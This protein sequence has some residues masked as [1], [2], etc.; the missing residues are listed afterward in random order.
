M[1]EI[2]TVEQAEDIAALDLHEEA[3]A[4][5]GRGESVRYHCERA[6]NSGESIETLIV[7]DR[8]GQAQGGDA[9]WGDWSDK[10]QTITMDDGECPHECGCGGETG[11][12]GSTACAYGIAAVNTGREWGSSIYDSVG[13]ATRCCIS[14]YL[15][16]S[17]GST[18]DLAALDP[19]EAPAMAHEL[20]TSN[21]GR[22][23][24][25]LDEDRDGHSVGRILRIADEVVAADVI[26][27]LINEA[28]EKIADSAASDQLSAE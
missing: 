3:I 18:E 17:N 13:R 28:R 23:W 27:D 21:E 20:L 9:A 5:L 2:T 6:K 22:H 16:G 10:Y 15:T 1:T 4:S 24:I 19:D 11:M 8:A 12:D 14:D 25:A 26:A 7:G